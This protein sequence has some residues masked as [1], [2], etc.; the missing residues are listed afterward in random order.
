[1]NNTGNQSIFDIGDWVVYELKCSNSGRKYTCIV[2]G[3]KDGWI[4]DREH[5]TGFS[6][7]FRPD[8]VIIWEHGKA[9]SKKNKEF[10]KKKQ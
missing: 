8:E 9:S 6:S 10:Q 1:M 5:G 2:V 7:S 3:E 4:L